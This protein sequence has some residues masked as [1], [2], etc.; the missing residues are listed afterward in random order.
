V[1]ER[2][3]W[4]EGCCPDAWIDR[5]RGITVMRMDTGWVVMLLSPPRWI[6]CIPDL[7]TAFEAAE[8]LALPVY[9]DPP[10]RAPNPTLSLFAGMPQEKCDEIARQWD[11]TYDPGLMRMV[12]REKA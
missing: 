1:S 2:D 10:A 6:G 5:R 8:R 9:P 4:E 7:E 3:G 12:L 11:A